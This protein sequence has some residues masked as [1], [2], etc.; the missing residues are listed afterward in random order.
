MKDVSELKFP[1]DL[2]YIESHEWVRAENGRARIGI[3]DYAQDQLGDIV[4]VEL[5]QVGKSIAKGGVFGS[6]ESVK[7]VSE[8]YMPIG[9]KIVE[10]NATLENSPEMVNTS[11]YDQGWM[12]VVEPSDPKEVNDLLTS[13]TYRDK[14]KG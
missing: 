1:E 11:P 13:R 8:L 5:P 10:I 4:Y 14:L 9:G 7:A 3:T 12:L 2:R 6:V